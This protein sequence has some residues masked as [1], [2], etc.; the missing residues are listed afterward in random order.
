MNKPEILEGYMRD[1]AGRLV[2]VGQIKEMAIQRD[3]LVRDLV[4]QVQ[5]AATHVAQ[6]KRRLLDDFAAHIA[7]AGEAL[8]VDLDGDQGSVALTSFDGTLKVERSIAPR[9]T[10]NGEEILAAEAQVRALVNELIADIDRAAPGDAP[11]TNAEALRSIVGRAFRR[12]ASGQIV[13]S[14]LLDFATLEIDDPRWRS[15]QRIIRAAVTVDDTVTYFRAYR[16][17]SARHKWQQIDLD[18]SRIA[19][20]HSAQEAA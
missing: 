19:P 13:L 11:S 17:E 6:V 15:A 4:G 9:L 5:A 12:N 1:S 7:L 10:M 16:R 3:A 2:P 8:G 14:R 18:F 20:A